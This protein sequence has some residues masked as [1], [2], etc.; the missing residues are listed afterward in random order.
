MADIKFEKSTGNVFKDL[1]YADPEL[2]MVK[3]QLAKQIKQI[4][5]HRHMT[6]AEAATLLGIDQPKVSRLL[7]GKVSGY[8]VDRLMKFL[9]ALD[10]DVTIQIK[11]KP[12]SHETACMGVAYA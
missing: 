3:V 6:Q 2:H 4:I 1:G 5:T 8:S 7:A 11:K 9:T 10:R 12:R